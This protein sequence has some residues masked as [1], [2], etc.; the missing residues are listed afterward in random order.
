MVFQDPSDSLD[1]LM[2]VQQI[3]VEP[4]LIQRGRAPGGYRREAEELMA[5]VG[6]NANLLDRRPAQLSGGQRQRVAIARALSTHPDLIV[7]DEA[8]SALDMSARGQILN[9]LAD[10]RE[11]R[12][13]AYLY[14]S[15]DLSLVRHVCDR[16]AVMYAGEIV[17]LADV[18]DLFRSPQHPY[19]Q[20]LLASVP[21][22]DPEPVR[23]ASAVRQASAAGEASPAGPQVVGC[24]YVPRCRRADDT[25]VNVKP[26]LRI[27]AGLHWAAC[28]R[29]GPDARYQEVPGP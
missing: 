21:S 25:C 26:P 12:G 28:H 18:E 14:I 11:E 27:V 7:C 4:L 3:V 23:A 16:V 1:P 24:P 9:L 29:P 8:A 5:S 2:T 6:L 13:L 17:E 22:P 19:T 10:L 20:Q 15:H